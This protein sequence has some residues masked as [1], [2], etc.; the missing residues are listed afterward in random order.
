MITEHAK[1]LDSRIPRGV[2][3]TTGNARRVISS[4]R[5]LKIRV[6][7]FGRGFLVGLAILVRVGLLE[8]VVH[9]C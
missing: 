2:T 6:L 1:I 3:E 5:E 7:G 9:V 8:A 4:D